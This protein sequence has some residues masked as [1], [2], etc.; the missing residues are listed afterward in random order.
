[1]GRTGESGYWISDKTEQFSVSYLELRMTVDLEPVGADEVL[2][3]E[4]R[5]VRAQEVEV[6]ELKWQ[7]LMLVKQT[8]EHLENFKEYY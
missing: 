3:V 1:M 2:L 5:V 4:H 8:F 6:L 7:I